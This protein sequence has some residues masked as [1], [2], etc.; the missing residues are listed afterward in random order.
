M[1]ARR[2]VDRRRVS[3]Q[4]LEGD[5]Q[6]VGASGVRGDRRPRRH[7]VVAERLGPV[8][9]ASC[10]R[11]PRFRWASE[12]AGS[13]SSAR[14]YAGWPPRPRPP[15][16]RA[17][18]R[19]SRRRWGVDGAPAPVQAAA[20]ARSGTTGH[21]FRDGEVQRELS[22]VGSQTRSASWTTTRSPD[23]AIRTPLSGRPSTGSC[24]RSASSA[25]RTLRVD[26]RCSRSSRALRSRTTSWKE[27]RYAPLGSAL[28]LEQP[29]A[30]PGHGCWSGQAPRISE[31]SRVVYPLTASTGAG[32]TSARRS[33]LALRRLLLVAADFRTALLPGSGG[34]LPLAVGLP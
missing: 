5:T 33:L 11:R 4:V 2:P 18:R 8:S 26:T 23:A 31:T 21:H 3:A 6:V 15:P 13:S 16:G 24:S 30:G 25:A 1:A 17:P 29:A 32:A 12:C 22:G 10:S 7:S 20:H 34:G 14:R 27:K 9:P 28:G 19:T